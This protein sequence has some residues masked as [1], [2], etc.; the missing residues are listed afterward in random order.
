[1]QHLTSKDFDTVI[2][3]SSAALVEFYAPWC[4]TSCY[5]F[6]S[7]RVTNIDELHFVLFFIGAAIAKTWRLSGPL[8]VSNKQFSEM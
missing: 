7:F 8:Q 1:M 6:L 4:V 5:R 2:D 3:G